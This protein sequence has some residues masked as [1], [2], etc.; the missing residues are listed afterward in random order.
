[1][2]TE[3]GEYIVG[4]YLKE[5]KD[6]HF[7]IYNVHPPVG[8]LEGLGELDVVGLDLKKDVAYLCE[9]TTHIQG[10][11]YGTPKKTICKVK[12]KYSRQKDYAK[13]YLKQ[14]K[15]QFFMLWSPVVSSREVLQGIKKIKGLELIINKDYARCIEELK[16]EAKK[17]TNNTGNPFFRTLQILERLKK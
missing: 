13:K 10:L 5:K 6:C 2:K 3:M 7:V 14:F 12:E 8:G 15:T 4:A 11:L 1:M 16:S 17:K 9:V